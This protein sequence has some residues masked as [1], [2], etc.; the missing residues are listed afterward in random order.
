M[1][2]QDMRQSRHHTAMLPVASAALSLFLESGK[3]SGHASSSSLMEYP[4]Q[5]HSVSISD[6][7]NNRSSEEGDLT[8]PPPPTLQYTNTLYCNTH[9]YNAPSQHPHPYI[10][11]LL[12]LSSHIL[13]THSP[14]H[15]TPT[16]SQ[17]L[18]T[19]S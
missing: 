18:L 12:I 4:Q 1:N 14:V 3:H 8:P 19:H 17:Y 5:H 7:E 16:S 10:A 15:Y 6:N 2:G 13:L 11:P 9:S